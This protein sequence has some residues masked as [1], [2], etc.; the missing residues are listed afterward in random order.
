MLVIVHAAM[1]PRCLNLDFRIR[2]DEWIAGDVRCA[3]KAHSEVI[4]QAN[5]RSANSESFPITESLYVVAGM[6]LPHPQLFYYQ[7]CR[8][9]ADVE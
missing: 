9:R 5:P 3:A 7:S 4:P 2:S 8:S 6:S 1:L